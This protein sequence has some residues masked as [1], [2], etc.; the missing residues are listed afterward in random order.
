MTVI[1]GIAIT[2][3]ATSGTP[4]DAS[5]PSRTSVSRSRSRSRPLR[6]RSRL[7]SRAGRTSSSR[8]SRATRTV[9]ARQARRPWRDGGHGLTRCTR[10]LPCA[11]ATQSVHVVAHGCARLQVV[12]RITSLNRDP[13]LAPNM[14][15]N[16]SGFA[17][18]RRT[19]T[20]APRSGRSADPVRGLQRDPAR[21]PA[22]R[23]PAGHGPR[24]R[25][26]EQRRDMSQNV[27]ASPSVA[28]AVRPM[29]RE[30]SQTENTAVAIGGR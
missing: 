21:H 11:A 9:S 13:S 17:C 6:R 20:S 4:T 14:A 15:I 25:R 3:Q 24:P 7:A 5:V 12:P 2:S 26:H 27:E 8:R 18:A 22:H 10:P 30:P 16:G 29:S 1:P 19:S 23:R 28:R